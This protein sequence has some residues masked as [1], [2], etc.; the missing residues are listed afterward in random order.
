LPGPRALYLFLERL[1][2]Y[3]TTHYIFYTAHLHDAF[4]EQGIGRQAI[5][6]VIYP[7]INFMPFLRAAP[8]SSRKRSRL[9]RAWGL[10]PEDMVLGYMARTIP[11]K[12]HHLAIEAFRRLSPRYPRLKLFL[13]GGGLWSVEQKYHDYLQ[14]LVKEMNLEGKVIFA[15]HQNQVIPFYQM[16]DLYIFPSLYEGTGNALI[17][18]MLLGLPVV[19][20]DHPMAREFCS[21][22]AVLCPY[23]QVEGLVAGVQKIIEE[24]GLAG[25]PGRIARAARRELV[26]RFLPHR[27]GEHIAEFYRSLDLDLG[28]KMLEEP[29]RR[30]AAP[31][32]SRVDV[33]AVKG[34]GGI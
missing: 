14:N 28:S 8:L 34:I 17:E 31:A 6:K 7:G 12:G 27:W 13:V 15:G 25:R 19:T 22:A 20:F 33:G 23:L 3:F 2:G 1:S 26:E 18:A 16:M 11:A 30:E 29:G 24:E 21:E 10:E 9:R 4:V 5:K 32:F